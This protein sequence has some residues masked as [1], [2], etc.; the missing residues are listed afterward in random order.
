ML[1][2]VKTTSLNL[3]PTVN[4]LTYFEKNWFPKL[5]NLNCKIQS[6]VFAACRERKLGGKL[7]FAFLMLCMLRGAQ[8]MSV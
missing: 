1:G 6:A 2:Q 3:K 8:A 7:V 5:L 4:R